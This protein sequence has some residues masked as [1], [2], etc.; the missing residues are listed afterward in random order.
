MNE[1]GLEEDGKGGSE[2]EEYEEE[3]VGPGEKSFNLYGG[4]RSSLVA[5]SLSVPVDCSSNPG[6]KNFLFSF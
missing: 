1:D 4:Q 2:Y 5:H 6:G 3:E